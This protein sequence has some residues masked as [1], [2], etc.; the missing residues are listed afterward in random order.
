MRATATGMF[1]KFRVM[2]VDRKLYP[3]HLAIS[4]DW[5]VHYFT[6]DMADSADN[7]AKEAAFLHDMAS[8]VGRRGMAALRTDR[9]RCSTSITAAS[10]SR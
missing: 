2:I 9:R 5:K 10:I 8:V 3:L 4:R 7:R 1:R 6:A